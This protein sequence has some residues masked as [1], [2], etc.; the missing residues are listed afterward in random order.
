MTADTIAKWYELRAKAQAD[1]LRNRTI[2]TAPTCACG[3]VITISDSGYKCNQC[4]RQGK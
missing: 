4:R 2:L 1:N 3:N